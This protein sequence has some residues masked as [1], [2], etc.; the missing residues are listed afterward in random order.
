MSKKPYSPEKILGTPFRK[1][2]GAGPLSQRLEP[3]L[4]WLK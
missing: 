4:P 1:I 3:L 2:R